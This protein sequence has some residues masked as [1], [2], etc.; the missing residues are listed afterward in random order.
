MKDEDTDIEDTQV[1][2]ES[3][4]ESESESGAAEQDLG[5]EWVS[6]EE[7]VT[8]KFAKIGQRVVLGGFVLSTLLGGTLGVIG[9]KIFS[10][11]DKTIALRAEF[12]QDLNDL[13]QATQTQTSQLGAA[14]DNVKMGT[15]TR[16]DKLQAENLALVNKVDTLEQMVT[17]MQLATQQNTKTFSDRVAVLEALSGDSPEVFS[18]ASSIASRLNALEERTLIKDIADEA[19][20]KLQEEPLNI[21]RISVKPPVDPMRQA[22]LDV[23]IDTFPRAKLLAAVK[24]QEKTAS[25]K[26]SWL[27]RAL[28]KHVRVGNDDAPDPYE[29]I[30]AVEAALKNGQVTDALEKLAQLNPPVRSSAAAWVEATK[31]AAPQIEK[32]Q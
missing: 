5:A 25:K 24:A 27:K 8:P 2:A 26:T 1:E 3:E 20:T 21:K 28:S 22:S 16:L 31:K 7:A 4:S 12:Q 9:S 14:T 11:P 6:E 19:S 10:G 15:Q 29:V 18:G 23:L 13:R 17:Q 30:E 32:T